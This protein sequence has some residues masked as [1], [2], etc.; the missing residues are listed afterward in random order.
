MKTRML[1]SVC[2]LLLSIFLFAGC[3]LHTHSSPADL[4]AYSVKERDGLMKRHAPR[5]YIEAPERSYNRI[6]G[7]IYSELEKK[8]VVDPDM[9]V[10][11]GEKRTFISTGGEQYTNYIYRVHFQGTPLSFNPFYL[12]A[13]ENIGL[14]VIVTTNRK[15][16]PVLYTSLHTCGCYLAFIPTNYMISEQLPAGWQDGLQDI[17][18]EILPAMF[19]IN[20]SGDDMPQLNILV[21][22]ATHRIM[23]AWLDRKSPAEEAK[24]A[25]IVIKSM[26]SLEYI[27]TGNN[28]ST[29]FFESGGRRMGYVKRSEKIWERL[30]ISWWAL[31]YRVGEDKYLGRDIDDG[32]VFYTSLKPWARE[33]SDLRDFASFLHYWGFRL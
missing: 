17:Y 24:E 31:D 9:P 32:P 15:Q 28:Y 20:N 4:L 7:V 27:E 5:F 22:D 10:M 16:E 13:G 6:G 2:S 3:S 23:D 33:A 29:S 8:V 21:R 25:D 12:G 14:L 18:G 30:F 11:Y 1:L 19:E 26:R